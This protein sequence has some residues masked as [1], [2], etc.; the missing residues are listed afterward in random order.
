MSRFFLNA[1]H[2]QVF[3]LQFGTAFVGMI[4]YM[5]GM[6]S[7]IKF[8][9]TYTPNPYGGPPSM[10]ETMPFHFTAGSIALLVIAGIF[11]IVSSVTQFG[12]MW[13][14]GTKLDAYFSEE[15]RKLNVKR[16]K[17]FFIYPLV[18]LPLVGTLFPLLLF[19]ANSSNFN[20]VLMG[21]TLILIVFG[22]LFAMFCM[23]H[24][25]YF[26]AKTYKSAV[27]Q[28]EAHIGDYIGEFFGV[29]FFPVGIWIL[30]PNINKLVNPAQGKATLD[31][32]NTDTFNQVDF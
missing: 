23:I 9:T 14:I 32:P 13:A 18:Y 31:S 26:V 12:W 29:W 15:T 2:W 30:Q 21:I 4:F 19:S 28:R 20:P 17:I 24:T 22:H 11:L 8:V 27:M 10:S 7:S 5:I 6:I 16:F 25:M 3:I 1:K